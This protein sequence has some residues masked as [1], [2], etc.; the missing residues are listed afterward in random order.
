MFLTEGAR[1]EFRARKPDGGYA[2]NVEGVTDMARAMI[3]GLRRRTGLVNA[4]NGRVFDRMKNTSL[5]YDEGFAKMSESD[6]IQKERRHYAEKARSSEPPTEAQLMAAR[7]IADRRGI[8]I[9][10]PCL[11]DRYAMESWLDAQ[12][13]ASRSYASRRDG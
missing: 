13:R 2:E 12:R 10:S 6:R 4:I 8:I 3:E 9:P 1:K 5:Y 7:A 11:V